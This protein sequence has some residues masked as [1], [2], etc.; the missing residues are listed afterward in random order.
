MDIFAITALCLMLPLLATSLFVVSFS[1]RVSEKVDKPER[2]K[3]SEQELKEMIQR[4]IS[5]KR[6][7][8]LVQDREDELKV[9]KER[10]R[11]ILQI[12][13]NV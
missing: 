5:L 6:D 2:E 4:G 13:P 1:W 11:K 9:L 10:G 12:D 7:K 8:K 3:Y